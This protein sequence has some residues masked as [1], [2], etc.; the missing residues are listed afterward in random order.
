[1]NGQHRRH[2]HAHPHAAAGASSSVTAPAAYRDGS[3]A[4]TASPAGRP[5]LRR[6]R[7]RPGGPAG[8]RPGVAGHRE[9][10]AD[11]PDQDE[12]RQERHQLDERLPALPVP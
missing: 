3:A 10:P 7:A 6:A 1:M 5:D 11:Q 2:R 12:Q 9:L 4:R 8:E